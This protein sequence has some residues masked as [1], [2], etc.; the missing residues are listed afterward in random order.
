[1]R[2]ITHL[3]ILFFWLL[4]LPVLAQNDCTD[5]IVVCGDTGFQG[6]AAVGVGAQELWDSN[7]CGSQ[8]N[9]SIWLK[10]PIKTT[11]VL[12]FTLTPD[13]PDIEE[14]FDFF[15]FGP[16]VTCG[17]LGQAIRCSTTNPFM[18]GQSDNLTGLSVSETDTSEGPGELGNSFVRSLNVTAGDYYYI[19]IDRPIGQSDFSLQWD[20][21]STFET[22]P[23]IAAPPVTLREC[24]PT[25]NNAIFNLNLNYNAVMGGQGG[26]LLSFH[27]SSNDAITGENDIPNHVLYNN[28]SNPQTIY[29]RLTNPLSGCFTTTEFNLEVTNG[30]TIPND[31]YTICDD[32]SDGNG[33]N[34]QTLV[35]LNAVTASIMGGQSTTGLTIGYFGSMSNALNN[36]LPL[37]TGF[38]NTTP[39]LQNLYVRV[40]ASNGCVLTKEIHL[41]V[42][43]QPAVSNT[44]LTQCDIDL[45]PDGITTF[46]LNEAIA[47]LTSGNPDLS[48]QFFETGDPAPLISPYTNLSNPQTLNAEIT[49]TLTGCKSTSHVTLIANMGPPQ[50]ISIAPLCDRAGIE[51]GLADFDLTTSDL[52]LTATETATF[53]KNANEALSVQNPIADPSNYTNLNPYNDAVF[54]RIDEAG[55]CVSISRLP[56]VVH[57]LPQVVR[58]EIGWYV[59]DEN[60][61]YFIAINAAILQGIPS[62]Y[63]YA[64]YKDGNLLAPTGYEISV[65]EAGTYKVEVTRNGCTATR[66]IVVSASAIAKIESVV[67]DDFVSDANT[68]TVHISS[69]NL[70]D[71][72][73]ALDNVNGPYQQSNTFFNVS[74]GIHQVYIDDLYACSILGPVQVN[75]LGIPKYFTPNGD[76]FNDTWNIV[77]VDAN[78]G[79]GASIHIY[80]RFGKLIRKISALDNGWDGTYN[81]RP[82]P[83]DDYWYTIFL[84][85]NRSAKGHFSLKR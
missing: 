74:P 73:F 41:H 52:N 10:L 40:V 18:A 5:A 79:G 31:T 61:D 25:G 81:D 62:D 75:V 16:N 71:Y 53:Y 69:A 70:G 54:V 39:N 2:N 64:W 51:N 26:L 34:A 8:E 22:L 72:V 12:A 38:Y 59:C 43:P 47:S 30:P 49:N 27:E 37:P 7:N 23:V 1:M 68:V 63:T 32:A 78:N 50:I 15:I 20:G 33:S 44:A 82:A 6:L 14:D 21:T 56:L 80:D 42:M 28:T 35:N 48:V 45:N 60:L 66:T 55:N 13:S 67:V 76:G 65:N 83:A 4:A 3:S 11:G 77:G 85:D 57:Q 9:N 19:V 17:N 46:D 58:D 84:N 29:V 36:I 24:A